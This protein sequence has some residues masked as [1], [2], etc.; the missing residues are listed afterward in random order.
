MASKKPLPPQTV[1]DLLKA[2]LVFS[3]TVDQVLEART[4]RE[5]VNVSLSPSKVQILRLLG[6]KATQTSTQIARFLGVSKPAVSQIV[7][8]MVRAKLVTRKPA[9]ADRREVHL[10]LTKKG[11][12]MFQAIRREQRHCVR[13]TVRATSRAELKRWTD[14]LNTMSQAVGRADDAYQQFCAQCGAHSNDSC[15]LVGGRSKC[16]FTKYTEK[17]SKRKKAAS[18]RSK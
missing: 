7:D 14:A 18:A 5:A 11:K 6:Q 1:D 17:A 15:V 2:M 4:V 3:R 16:L 9:T 12:D 8:S 13:N 10:R